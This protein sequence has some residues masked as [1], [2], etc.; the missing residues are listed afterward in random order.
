MNGK[1][2]F[3]TRTNRVERVVETCGALVFTSWHKDEIKTYRKTEI[4]K[5]TKVEVEQYLN[6]AATVAEIRKLAEALPHG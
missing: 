6:D 1:L 3:N 5:A 4:Q 2:Y